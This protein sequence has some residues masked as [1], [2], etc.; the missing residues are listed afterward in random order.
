MKD[1]N[2]L[3]AKSATMVNLHALLIGIS[4][5][6][7]NDVCTSLQGA[8]AD[9]EAMAGYLIDQGVPAD[10]IRKLTSSKGAGD[11]PAEPREAWPTYENMVAAI[12]QL[13]AVAEPGEHVLIHYAGHGGR[14]TPT[15]IPG[16]KSID[17]GLIPPDVGGPGARYLRDVELTYLLYRMAE[18]GLMVTLIVDACHSAGVFRGRR[19]GKPKLVPRGSRKVDRTTAAPDSLVA[20]PEELKRVWLKVHN[21]AYVTRGESPRGWLAAAK[22]SVLLAACRSVESAYEYPFAGRF[23]GLLTYC[24][25]EILN[26]HRELSFQ[27]IQRRLVDRIHDV[28]PGQTPVLEGDDSRGVFGGRHHKPRAAIEVRKVEQDGRVRLGA[29]QAVGL[30]A[31][32]LVRVLPA[33]SDDH[34]DPLRRPVVKITEVG[35]SES[36]GYA[37]SDGGEAT[38][39]PGDRAVLIDPGDRVRRRVA[40]I[41][42]GHGD[43]TADTAVPTS[44]GGHPGFGRRRQVLRDGGRSRRHATG[45]AGMLDAVRQELDRR[46]SGFLELVGDA[47]AADDP[48]DFKVAA[49]HDGDPAGAGASRPWELEIRY[50]N[51]R[52]IAD[53]PRLPMTDPRSAGRA[54]DCLV[55]LA[56]YHNVRELENCDDRSPLN[57]ALSVE[58]SLLGEDFAPSRDIEPQPFASQDSIPE[59]EVGRWICLTV[60][61]HSTQALEITVLDL[62]PGWIIEQIHPTSGA[63]TLDGGLAVRLPFRIRLP[64]GVRNRRKI[65]KVFATVEPTD[66]RWLQLPA[67]G[68]PQRTRG[69]QG[70]PLEQLFAK[71]AQDGPRMRGP[72]TRHASRKWTSAQVE[73][74]MV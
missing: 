50:A 73:F 59:V 17:E 21:Q 60:A 20:S 25:L 32:A 10:R 61:N 52:R 6:Q 31:G 30:A 68:T 74:E 56:R 47:N 28:A 45:A 70:D 53:L 69:P 19:P 11:A 36:W 46:A 22:G 43:P 49:G 9:V 57:G 3:A 44:G 13:T 71:I 7:D 5:Y 37:T 55:Q 35:A 40:L 27:Q 1:D 24:L 23:R 67:I 64:S 18:K 42:P 38:V 8:V 14:V 58:L 72:K 34:R 33:T 41:P 54:V 51:G 63:E 26:E 62:Q 15:L 48:P 4:H 39:Q 66:F 2:S 65:F 16:S 29:G 12:Q